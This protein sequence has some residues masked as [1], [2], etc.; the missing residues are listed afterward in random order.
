[1]KPKWNIPGLGFLAI[2]ILLPVNL[3]AATSN[4]T[5][6][7]VAQAMES[8]AV[9]VEQFLD[10]EELAKE[11][12]LGPI[13]GLPNLKSSGGSEVRRTLRQALEA[14]GLRVSDD[15]R[16]QIMGTYRLVEEKEKP[17]DDFDSLGLEVVLQILNENGDLLAEPEI[18]V[19]G[20]QILQIAGL[21]VDVPTKGSEKNRQ[22]E[23]IRQRREPVTRLSGN[24]VRTGGPFGIE[25]IVNNSGHHD[26]R[27]PR[28]DSKKRPFV[29][30][31]KKEEYF[32]RIHNHADFEAAV[33]LLIDG[34]NV[35]V[36][37]KQE[38][39]GPNSKFVIGAGK[40]ADIPGWVITQDHSKAFEV[41]GYEGSVAEQHGKPQHN[42]DVGSITAVFQASWSGDANRPS[43]EPG[44]RAKGG[45]ATREGRDIDTEYKV[46]VRD[47]GVV[48]ST[49]TVRYDR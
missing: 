9:A 39:M 48:R 44:G 38:G 15:A 20:R 35:F 29:D 13:N 2:A 7:V 36:N 4:E 40:A 46:V 43:D 6:Q 22:K 24:Q 37:A 34:V 21:N 25:I 19:W 10:S 45:K 33:T 14:K 30:L 28:L 27:K 12:V 49:I 8:V 18:K 16:T 23:I 42:P 11:L 1:M 31:N 32:V 26:S 41:S 17:T 47:F 3:V 5:E